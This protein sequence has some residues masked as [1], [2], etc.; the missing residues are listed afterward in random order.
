MPVTDAGNVGKATGKAEGVDWFDPSDDV[1][2]RPE[3]D[4]TRFWER[5]YGTDR[6]EVAAN[7]IFANN[8]HGRLFEAVCR[9]LDRRAETVHDHR[10]EGYCHYRTP[11][12]GFV[13]VYRAPD[14]APYAA[15][16]LEHLVSAGA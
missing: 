8:G 1:V 13:T 5:R 11:S 12:S 2:L 7:V 10:T 16:N 3:K 4:R 14:P 6:I 9:D 15:A